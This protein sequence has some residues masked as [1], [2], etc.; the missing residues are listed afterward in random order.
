M[1]GWTLG[2]LFV[3]GWSWTV[4][5]FRCATRVQRTGKLRRNEEEIIMWLSSIEFLIF[6]MCFILLV[7][8]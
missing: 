1:E 3:P 7:L 5:C 8:G 6:G 4:H 2:Y